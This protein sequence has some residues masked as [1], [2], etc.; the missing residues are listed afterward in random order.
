[1]LSWDLPKTV[2]IVDYKGFNWDKDPSWYWLLSYR[3]NDLAPLMA[4]FWLEDHDEVVASQRGLEDV[5][6]RQFKADPL[7]RVYSNEIQKRSVVIL[8]KSSGTNAYVAI[9]SR[10][11]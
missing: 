7:D 4:G 9:Y 2:T 8:L 3:S 5:F 6:R 11:P 10:H 1:M